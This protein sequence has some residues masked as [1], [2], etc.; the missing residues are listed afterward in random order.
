VIT[1]EM[2][3][4]HDRDIVFDL[5][6]RLLCEL[7]AGGDAAD[8]W[9]PGKAGRDWAQN[10]D[11]FRVF[12]ARDD[13]KVV[14]MLTLVECFALYADGSFGIINELFV[15]ADYRSQNVGRELVAAAAA[16]GRSRGWRRIDVTAPAGE[17][18]SRT[19]RFYEREGFVFTGPK[20][21]L[22]L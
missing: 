7:R 21:K 15:E 16:Y 19:V 6:G 11:R 18:W 13:S 14:G 3:S 8:T 4:L 20:L 9:D 5:V 17:K 12:A 10:E 22:L 2:L 1:V